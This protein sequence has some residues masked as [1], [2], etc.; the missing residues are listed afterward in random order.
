MNTFQA[1]TEPNT[2]PVVSATPAVNSN[3]CRSGCTSMSRRSGNPAIRLPVARTCT[4]AP[5][6][7]YAITRPRTL[8]AS[9]SSTDSVSSC[10]TNRTRLAPSDTRTAISPCLAAAR[11]SSMLAT[12]VHAMS[13]SMP[14]ISMT[15]NSGFS[16]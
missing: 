10:R 6:P 14:T 9:D 15:T 5:E 8:A 11:A 7:K 12:F 1:G 3:T 16:N 13:N 4:S 2:M